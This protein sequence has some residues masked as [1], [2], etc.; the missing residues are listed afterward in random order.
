M[1]QTS[2]DNGTSLDERLKLVSGRRPASAND[3]ES[4]D[5][6]TS[7]SRCYATVRGS[8]DRA[9][10][11]ELRWLNGKTIAIDWAWMP[12]VLWRDDRI[13]LL[14][15]SRGFAITIAGRNLRHLRNRLGLRSV[16]WV[17]QMLEMHDTGDE[18]AECVFGI[19]VKALGDGE[20]LALLTGT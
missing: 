5:I 16:A 18:K 20:E 4:D 6:E 8:R 9:R 3:D 14:F 19:T 1:N 7:P 10:S 12:D 17:Q 13:V 15:S 11:L 2:L